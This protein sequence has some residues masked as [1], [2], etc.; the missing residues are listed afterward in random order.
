MKKDQ[1]WKANDVSFEKAPKV[2][3]Q[4]MKFREIEILF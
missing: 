4:Q 1:D 3:F 2:Q